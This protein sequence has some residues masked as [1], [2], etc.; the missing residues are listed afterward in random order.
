MDWANGKTEFGSQILR[1][2]FCPPP[3]LDRRWVSW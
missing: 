1:R 2:A 3:L